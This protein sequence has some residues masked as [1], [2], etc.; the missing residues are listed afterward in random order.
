MS[1]RPVILKSL[2]I[3]ALVILSFT[4]IVTALSG[5]MPDSEPSEPVQSEVKIIRSSERVALPAERPSFQPDSLSV[6]GI[7]R[8]TNAARLDHGL[9]PLAQNHLLNMVAEARIKDMFQQQYFD[10]ISPSGQGPSDAARHVGYNYKRLGENIASGTFTTS[11]NILD[12]W[13]QSP[14]HRKNILSVETDEIGVAWAKGAMNG[15]EIVLA[16]QIFGKHAPAVADVPAQ[17]S[18]IPPNPNA[19][20]HI[21]RQ[22]SEL[23]PLTRALSQLK[24]ELDRDNQYLEVLRN[25]GRIKTDLELTVSSYNEKVRRYNQLLSEV[26]TKQELIQ[27]ALNDYSAKVEDYKACLADK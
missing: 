26:Q 13:L 3:I 8:L 1:N 12:A 18:C 4:V 17:T 10:H 15:S 20:G 2:H 27:Q 24:E 19:P 14:G 7:I 22:R 16:V 23:A 25:D 21:D 6:D 5:C 11:R 9:P